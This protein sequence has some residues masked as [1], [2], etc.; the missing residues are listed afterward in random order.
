MGEGR[1]WYLLVG[2]EGDGP[3]PAPVMAERLPT[4][5]LPGHYRL[6]VQ[7]FGHG[8]DLAQAAA[9]LDELRVLVEREGRLLSVNVEVF[10]PDAGHLA[11]IGQA[12]DERG[13]ERVATGRRYRWTGRLDLAMD[14]EEIFAGFSRSGRRAIRESEKAG[15]RVEALVDE[16][17][18]PRM[19]ALWRETFGR[20]GLTPPA[21]DWPRL[22]AFAR[23]HPHLYRIVG[24]FGA[25]SAGQ[26]EL[27]AFACC[28]N[29]GDH[30][31]YSDGASTDLP[32]SRLP[33]SYAPVWDLIRWA[34]TQGCTWFDMGG[35]SRDSTGPT[36]GIA[37]FKRRFTD[38]IIE[39]GS[40]WSY[41]SPS[42]RGWLADRARLWG[43][44]VRRSL[45]GG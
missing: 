40:E 43:K 21:R 25:P 32:D 34:R 27:V 12:A 36:G 15:L 9:A 17:L 44:G 20:T 8:I 1:H 7:H 37:E 28:M 6:R 24:A 30:S 42:F 35:V 39:V 23:E 45:G 41:T 2:G 16:G 13:Y 14:E 19:A 5:T 4:R 18:A 11:A 38:D 29:N 31:V 22:V 10:T 3:A 33:L 26:D